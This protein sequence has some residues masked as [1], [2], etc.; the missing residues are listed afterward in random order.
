MHMRILKPAALATALIFSVGTANA[1]IVDFDT[2]PGGGVISSGTEITNQYSS[3]GVTFGAFEN[4][5]ITP[6]P[7][8]LYDHAALVENPPS[9]SGNA[10][11]NC[12]PP[13]CGARAD[14]LRISFD[15]PVNDVSWFT[16]SEGV[17][18]IT[19][20]AYDAGGVLLETV[21]AISPYGG[22]A[23]TF[24]LTEFTVDGI[25][26]IDMLQPGDNTGW[27]FDNLSFDNPSLS[28]EPGPGPGPANVPAPATAALLAL[29]VLM[30]GRRGRKAGDSL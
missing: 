22:T 14:I 17:S 1:V 24:V 11:F 18:P 30:F 6:G 27:G 7:F 23:Y 20:E 29:G 4:N 19:F 8:A 16:D 12:P 28:A 25:S 15:N 2:L 26:R 9:N 13:G 5:A 21:T 3:L 10:L